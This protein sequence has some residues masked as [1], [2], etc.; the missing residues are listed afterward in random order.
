[1][2]VSGAH[3]FEA[4]P[5][6][7]WRVLEDPGQ[8]VFILPGCETLDQVSENEYS[9]KLKIKVGPVQGMF[10]GSIALTDVV[11]DESATISV[12]GQGAPGFLNGTGR[13]RLEATDS[14]C[15]LHYEGEAQIGGRLAAVGQRL[16]DSSSKA[17]IRQ[18]LEA[19]EA[20]VEATHGAG[21]SEAEAF[22]P[23]DS[24]SQ[25]EFAAGVVRH[26]IGDWWAE[27]DRKALMRRAISGAAVIAAAY[28]LYRWIT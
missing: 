16:L 4:P 11:D 22:V 23:P 27:A 14:G 3:E 6:A 19:L 1:V 25:T 13:L 12:S 10:D 26:M 7:V 8:L 20:R 18:G 5:E 15:V 21:P 9:G 28:V 24:P 17:I 2:D